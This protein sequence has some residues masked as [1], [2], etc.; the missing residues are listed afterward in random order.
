MVSFSSLTEKGSARPDLPWTLSTVRLAA[1][2]TLRSQA[3]KAI[4]AVAFC[5]RT[6]TQRAM[7]LTSSCLAGSA[8]KSS[9]KSPWRGSSSVSRRVAKTDGFMRAKEPGACTSWRARLGGYSAS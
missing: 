8:Q 6:L 1:K 9:E 7:C 3:R 4:L 2:T 5:S